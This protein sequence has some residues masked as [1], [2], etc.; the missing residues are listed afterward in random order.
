[1][2]K[3]F[4]QQRPRAVFGKGGWMDMRLYM[5]ELHRQHGREVEARAIEDELRSLLQ[6]ADSDFRFVRQLERLEQSYPP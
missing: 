4:S 2:L 6:Y 5:A 3:T 1:M